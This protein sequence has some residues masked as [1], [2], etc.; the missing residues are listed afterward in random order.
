MFAYPGFAPRK[1]KRKKKRARCCLSPLKNI[2]LH[3][4]CCRRRE[5]ERKRSRM[6][7]VS[8]ALRVR[9]SARSVHGG[10]TSIHDPL[11]PTL[12]HQNWCRIRLLLCT[13]FLFS[14]PKNQKKGRSA[15]SPQERSNA[16]G[17]LLSERS[18]FVRPFLFLSFSRN[19]KQTSFR[20]PLIQHRSHHFAFF[21]F[22][23]PNIIFSCSFS[24]HQ[25]QDP[26]RHRTQGC[27][28]LASISLARDGIPRYVLP[29]Y[30]RLR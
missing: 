16:T 15:P 23:P 11:H 17:P 1:K 25:N 8:G 24:L 30:G 2:C 21:P 22:F 10:R 26:A 3:T 27:C 5:R 28:S 12:R 9:A 20:S 13:F 7:L 19:G 14:P 6:L 29:G 18:D 4:S